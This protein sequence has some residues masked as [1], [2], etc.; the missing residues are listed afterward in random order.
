MGKERGKLTKKIL[1]LLHLLMEFLRHIFTGITKPIMNANLISPKNV[2]VLS[3]K[4]GKTTS[5]TAT[6]SVLV[7]TGSVL[8]SSSLLSGLTAGTVISAKT[9]AMT[10]VVS[11]LFLGGIGTYSYITHEN[12]INLI[13]NIFKVHNTQNQATNQPQTSPTS[14]T[15][16]PSTQSSGQ[17][18]QKVSA[19]NLGYSYSSQNSL[20]S[21]K[22][23]QISNQ[24][25]PNSKQIL[26]LSVNTTYDTGTNPP[27]INYTVPEDPDKMN[28]AKSDNLTVLDSL[29]SIMTL[30]GE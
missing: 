1:H 25:S 27:S 29:V 17:S 11:S 16:N 4:T 23:T 20:N 6:K 15:T 19:T 18:K 24:N 22:N 12:P 26:N 2:K 14:T 7:G 21:N 5:K 28:S 30:M 9:L 3:K 8:G 13:G 10:L